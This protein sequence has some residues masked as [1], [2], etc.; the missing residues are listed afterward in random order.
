[1]NIY[2]NDLS[3]QSDKSVIENMPFIIGFKQL[4]ENLSSMSN[5]TFRASRSLWN[6]PISGFNV[7]T[8]ECS[9][10]TIIPHEYATLLQALYSKFSPTVVNDFPYFSGTK[11]MNEKSPSVGTACVESSPVISFIFDEKYKADTI[12]GW[13]QK[14]EKEVSTAEV[15]N[16]FKDK[17]SIYKCLADINIC[18]GYNP[19]ENPMWNKELSEKLLE[20]IDFISQDAKSRQ[21]LLYK[22]GKMVA[23]ANGWTYNEEISKLNSNSGQLRYIFDSSLSFVEYPIAYI[24]IDMEGPDLAFELCDKR[25]KHKGECSW[26]GKIKKPQQYHDIKVKR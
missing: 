12:S 2:L 22:Y 3:L 15:N 19:L 25:G 17:P 16:I 13:L 23:E 1:M 24:S 21:G 11:D 10:G 14:N 18:R 8:G 7:M 20:G 6:T 5:I 4:I 26:D 9:K